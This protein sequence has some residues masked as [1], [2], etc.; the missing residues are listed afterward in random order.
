MNK[1]LSTLREEH[2]HKIKGGIYHETQIRFCYNSNRI[3]GS[4]LSE[5]QTRY[6]FETNT[7]STG[8]D[9]AA[10]VD[11]IIETVNH[12]S[13]FDF[14]L[15]AAEQE[16]SE[17]IIKEFHRA[18]KSGTSDSKKDWFKTGDYKSMP[19]TVGGIETAAPEEVQK[20]IKTLLALYNKKQGALPEGIEGLEDLENIV[21]FH[22]QFEKIHPFQDGNGRVG[23]LIMFKEC[24][25]NNV[26]P[27]I[28]D[29]KHKFFYYR[30][31]HEFERESGFLLDTCRSAQDE[32]AKLLRY[33]KILF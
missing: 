26:V 16:L 23:R 9:S 17:D 30:G 2:A 25:K 24:L 6:I 14:M 28:I 11:D 21:R 29:E 22:Y 33:F 19:N 4:K 20:E 8:A 5:E 18:I 31:L 12:F 1:L 7:I 27:F 10:N 15:G 32:Y 3:E 13:A